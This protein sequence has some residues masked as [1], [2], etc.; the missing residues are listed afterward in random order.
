MVQR[1]VGSENY[2]TVVRGLLEMY[3]LARAG[4]YESPEADAV[5]DDMDGPWALLS[6]GERTKAFELSEV[7]NAICESPNSTDVCDK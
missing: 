4:K 2:L 5:R 7:I 1:I 3:A 6:E